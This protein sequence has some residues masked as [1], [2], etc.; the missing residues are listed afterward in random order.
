MEQDNI[1]LEGMVF[2]GHHGTLPEERR[3]GQQFVVDVTA[4]LDLQAAGASDDLAKSIDY[5]EVYRIARDVLEGPPVQLTETVAERIA[6]MVLDRHPPVHAVQV[7]V[8]KPNVRLESTVLAGSIIAIT[9]RRETG[10]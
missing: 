2:F 7:R 8:R 1:T 3:L 5:S 6:A 9:R 4:Y 10:A